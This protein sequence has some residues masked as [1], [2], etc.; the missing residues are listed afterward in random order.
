ME[1]KTII[2]G[3]GHISEETA[4][5]LKSRLESRG[6]EVEILSEEQARDKG[7]RFDK[8]IIY[9]ARPTL[10]DIDYQPVIKGLEDNRPWYAKFDNKR[11]R[12]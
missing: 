8:P 7:V 3:N 12:R 5:S 9:H 11:K 4:E 10:P 2:I 1:K 6:I